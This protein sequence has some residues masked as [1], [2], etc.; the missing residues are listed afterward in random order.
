MAVLSIRIE[1]STSD[2]PGCDKRRTR[3]R[4]V[5]AV[6]V[7]AVAS[8]A[9]AGIAEATG[10]VSPTPSVYTALSPVKVLK[11]RV[12][13]PSTTAQP[14]VAGGTTSV[15]ASATSVVLNVNVSGGTTDGTLEVYPYGGSSDAEPSMRW[16]VGQAVTQQLTVPVGQGGKISLQNLTGSVVV[17]AHL[18][19]FY[20]P[21]DTSYVT[22]PT[23]AQFLWNSQ[24]IFET[25]SG[26]YTE[27]FTRYDDV[28][29]PTLTQS[30]LDSGSV[31]VFMTPSPIN[32]PSSWLPLPY[33]FDSSFG[34]TY[35]FTYVT[36]PGHVVLM[37]YF[38]QTDPDATL[39]TLSTFPMN[40]YN[41][42][43]VVTP[44][45]AGAT[46]AAHAQPL[47]KGHTTCRSIPNG[48]ACTV[49]P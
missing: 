40:T 45:S 5:T 48:K 11:A 34:F 27:Y 39:P 44:N 13:T 17:T 32:T 46:P 20:A 10:A 41:F 12:I 19:G 1:R 24:Y 8:L 49:R 36:S 7:V 25:S 23:S 9:A 21:P 22:S 42:K 28:S 4:V 38:I 29:V 43:I 2:H 16:T 26:S 18:L 15:P 3:R 33:Q 37:F 30:V 6:A 35:N 47:P 31:Q 14:V